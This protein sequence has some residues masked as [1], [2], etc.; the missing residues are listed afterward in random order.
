MRDFI[1]QKRDEIEK[2]KEKLNKLQCQFAK[3][4]EV[5]YN[6]EYIEYMEKEEKQIKLSRGEYIEYMEP[7]IKQEMK[8]EPKLE[9]YVEYPD[10]EIKSEIKQ[11]QE[12]QTNSSKGEYVQPEIKSE[13]KQKETDYQATTQGSL[14][15]HI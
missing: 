8:E 13:M 12:K 15:R 7:E 5:R 3:N 9:E 6:K 1:R 11:E 4:K 10:P 14:Q 2:Q